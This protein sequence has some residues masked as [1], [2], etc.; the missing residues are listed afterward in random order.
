MKKNHIPV[1]RAFL[2]GTAS[3]VLT[4]ALASPA[5]AASDAHSKMA[6]N[7]AERQ[8][9]LQ[10]HLAKEADHLGI[11]AAQQAQWQAYANAVESPT[12]NVHKLPPDA[13][14]ASIVRQRADM[15]AGHA[16]KL[17]RI[18]DAAAALQAVLTQE[19]RG[20]FARMVRHAGPHGWREARDRDR[21]HP[22]DGGPAGA[23]E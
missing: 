21:P 1:L 19:Q 15:A 9:H 7:W 23:A 16:A 8:A 11:T 18:A 12:G 17:V 3:A 2:A 5:S 22:E 6:H 4:F 10:A 20:T 14:A 13:D